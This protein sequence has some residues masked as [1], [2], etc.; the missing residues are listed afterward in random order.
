MDFVAELRD[1]PKEHDFIICFDSDGCVFDTME[2]KHKEC[3]CPAFIKH[4]GLQAVSKYAREVW[5]F[6]NLYSKT[7]GCNRFMGVQYAFA[8][9]QTRPAFRE[10]GVTLPD[11]RAFDDWLARETKLGNPA[12]AAH[13]ET[14]G[15]TS[16]QR[17]LDWSSEVNQRVE[18][19]VH[20]VAPFPGVREILA[21][22]D[23]K[24]DMMVV[25]Q[26]PLEA[27]AREWQE[28][29]MDGYV[30]MIAGQEHGTKTEHIRFATEGKGYAKERVLMV[31]DAPG[32][33]AAA[34]ANDAL[35]YPIVPGKEEQ[36]WADFVQEG[37]GRF[38]D[39][40]FAGEYQASLLDAFDKSLPEKPSW[41]DA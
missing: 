13:L 40:S 7:R 31:G 18:E 12:L 34:Q 38:F 19:M 5:D 11:C 37:L 29:E 1:M 3:F 41:P 30:Q 17:F 23:G 4:M 35:F 27:L 32:D 6:V 10:R 16:L 39:G 24:A 21:Q 8:M 14:S 15:E 33:L 9:L 25:S 28:H 20:G 2:L 36:S 26:T 22:A